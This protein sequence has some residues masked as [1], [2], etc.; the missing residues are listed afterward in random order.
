MLPSLL[1][2]QNNESYHIN[3]YIHCNNSIDYTTLS[4]LGTN[5]VL[6]L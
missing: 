4:E 1:H 6:Q 5:I 2:I 3:K